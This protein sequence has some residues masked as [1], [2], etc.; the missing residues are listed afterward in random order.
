MAPR[1]LW[2]LQSPTLLNRLAQSKKWQ[3]SVAD[4]GDGEGL[5]EST[6]L[7]VPR[8]DGQRRGLQ[9]VFVC[10]PAQV[11]AA[12]RLVPGERIVLVAHQGFAQKLPA[13]PDARCIVS[14][15]A[16]VDR[17][18]HDDLHH[19]RALHHGLRGITDLCLLRPAFQP[20][21]RWQWQANRAFALCSRPSTREP[22]SLAV[23]ENYRQLVR[24]TIRVFGQAQADG[25]LDPQARRSWMGRSSAYVSALHARRGLGL[26]ELEA[27]SSGCPV[28]GTRWGELIE[29][30][31]L[32]RAVPRRGLFDL[33]DIY[34]AAHFIDEISRDARQASEVCAQQ[35]AF[36]ADRYTPAAMDASICSLLDSLARH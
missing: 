14:F 1:V 7:Q 34:N 12:R 25:F 26:A 20:A 19:H 28:V 18:L 27:M 21:P 15:S 23:L 11:R 32:G 6:Q 9:A 5:A 13:C 16:A 29:L 2:A 33:A 30:E 3:M 17:W 36:V 31:R 10:S 8:W 24:A 35:A 4:L 22:L